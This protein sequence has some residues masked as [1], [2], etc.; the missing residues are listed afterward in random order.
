LILG[1]THYP[2]LQEQI[3][4][5]LGP[6]VELID[7]A[8]PTVK[9]LSTILEKK[10]LLNTSLRGIRFRVFTSDLPRNFI[11]VGE[12]FL[13]EKLPSIKVVS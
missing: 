3:R 5:F 10:N 12:R 8:G 7:S 2:L 4:D 9:V 11:P 13:G 6:E 1:C